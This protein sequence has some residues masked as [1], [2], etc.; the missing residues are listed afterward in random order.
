MQRANGLN[1]FYSR[2]KANGDVEL[3]ID[4]TGAPTIDYPHVHLIHKGTGN[5]DITASLAR[6]EHPWRTTLHNPSG[7]EVEAAVNTAKSYLPVR[8]RLMKEGL[9]HGYLTY[10][11]DGNNYRC[12]EILWN[13][14]NI[15]SVT[16]TNPGGSSQTLYVGSNF[17]MTFEKGATH[18][19]S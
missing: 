10:R 8:A 7:Q 18:N 3:F 11:R 14:M 5:V 2:M 4:R 9:E 13:G 15:N 16:V 6:G 12:L 19:L 17:N 1:E